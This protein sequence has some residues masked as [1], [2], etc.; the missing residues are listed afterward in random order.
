VPFPVIALTGITADEDTRRIEQSGVA[1]VLQKPVNV[2]LLFE[3]LRKG[4][5]RETVAGSRESVAG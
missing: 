2:A 1:A 5:S 3:A 4:L